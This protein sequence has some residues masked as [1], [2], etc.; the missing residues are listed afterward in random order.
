MIGIPSRPGAAPCCGVLRR[1]GIRAAGGLVLVG[2]SS[3]RLLGEAVQ[4][5]LSFVLGEELEKPQHRLRE[6]AGISVLKVGASQE[7]GTDHF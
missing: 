3:R 2:P 6:D 4:K 5:R 1:A 7:V